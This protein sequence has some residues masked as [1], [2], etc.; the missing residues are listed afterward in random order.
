MTLVKT[1]ILS[2]SNPRSS[3]KDR[4]KCVHRLLPDGREALAYRPDETK[5]E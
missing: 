1:L 5:K 3:L 2:W 4:V